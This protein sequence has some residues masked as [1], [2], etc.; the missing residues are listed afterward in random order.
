MPLKATVLL[1]NY[2]TRA[3]RSKKEKTYLDAFFSDL[4]SPLSGSVVS[5]TEKV[6]TVEEILITT[7]EE[8]KMK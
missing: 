7:F 2:Q 3:Q 5:L 6:A 4:T 8:M 1:L